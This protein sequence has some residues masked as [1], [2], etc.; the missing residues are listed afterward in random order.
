MIAIRKIG[1]SHWHFDDDRVS[2]WT[3]ISIDNFKIDI[4]LVLIRNLTVLA[5]MAL[6]DRSIRAN[7]KLISKGILQDGSA[8]IFIQLLILMF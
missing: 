2:D 6:K 3:T 5:N 8:N 4:S 7:G 1:V